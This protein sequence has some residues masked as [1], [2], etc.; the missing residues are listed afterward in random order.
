VVQDAMKFPVVGSMV[1]FSLYLAFKFL[2]KEMVNAILSGA[3]G[4]EAWQAAVG[5]GSGAGGLVG[6]SAG[7]A[8]G[9]WEAAAAKGAGGRATL[10]PG[11]LVESSLLVG[12]ALNGCSLQRPL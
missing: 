2:P 1:L 4:P 8:G 10:L 5:E 11:R 7:Q 6:N 9:C 12:P 3:S